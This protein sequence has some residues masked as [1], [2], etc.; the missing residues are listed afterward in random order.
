M[1]VTDDHHGSPTPRSTLPR[2][3]YSFASR[4]RQR[5]HVTAAA[6]GSAHS[7]LV[8]GSAQHSAMRQ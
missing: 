4:R 1:A 5:L 7:E 8:P 6:G 3:P 2:W